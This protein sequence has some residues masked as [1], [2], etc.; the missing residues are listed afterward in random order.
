MRKMKKEIEIIV[1]DIP[2]SYYLKDLL[3][4]CGYEYTGAAFGD[5]VRFL[6]F[7]NKEL[8]KAADFIPVP[9]PVNLPEIEDV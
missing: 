4:N 8:P 7:K 9:I 5:G 3:E 6:W 2:F 1:D